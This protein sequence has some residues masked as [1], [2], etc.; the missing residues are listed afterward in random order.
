MVKRLVPRGPGKNLGGLF[1]L[2]FVRNVKTKAGDRAESNHS[3]E[4][5]II[6]IVMN[7]LD[8]KAGDDKKLCL[9]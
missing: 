3:G 2:A 4:V 6:Q 7:E 8:C 1:T 9:K 5:F